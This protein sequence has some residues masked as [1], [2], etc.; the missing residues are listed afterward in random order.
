MDERK[1][2]RIKILAAV[3]FMVAA[4]ICYSCGRNQDSGVPGDG[5]FLSGGQSG[6]SLLEAGTTSAA[7]IAPADGIVPESGAAAEADA[8]SGE[9]AGAADSAAAQSTSAPTVYV[10]I[11][12]AVE[13]PGVYQVEEGSRVFQVVEEAGGFLEEAAPDYLNMADAVSDGMKLVVPYADELEAGQAYGETGQAA[14]GVFASGP[15]K[16]NINTADKAALMT[17]KGIGESRAEDIIR[18]REQN[19]GFQKI[20]DIMNVSGIKDAFFEKIRDD[21]TV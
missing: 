4:G 18:Y 5:I 19:G 3:I 1:K 2:K 6:L 11:C 12:G 14:A 9:G 20:E 17:L 13:R 15:A 21:I 10:H 7:G 8:V 16:I